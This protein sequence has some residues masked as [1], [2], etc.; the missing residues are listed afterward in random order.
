[1]LAET[2]FGKQAIQMID[3]LKLAVYQFSNSLPYPAIGY[4]AASQSPTIQ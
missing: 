3:N 4:K 2:Q 1:L